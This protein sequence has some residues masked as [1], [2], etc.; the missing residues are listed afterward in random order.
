GPPI[1]L[2]TLQAI[3]RDAA[4][5]TEGQDG[6]AVSFLVG[7]FHSL[8]HAGLTRRSLINAGLAQTKHRSGLL[9]FAVSLLLGPIATFLIVILD[10]AT[11]AK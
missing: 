6:V 4:C 11:P 3:S 10:P 1:P 8:Q 9:W 2:S 7:L 5:K